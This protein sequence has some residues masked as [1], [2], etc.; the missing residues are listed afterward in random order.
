[1]ITLT[2]IIYEGN[3]EEILR[4]ESWFFKFTNTNITNKCLIINNITSIDSFN[5]KLARLYEEGLI[6]DVVYVKHTAN[7]AIRYFKLDL[8]ENSLGYNYT[9]PYF[10]MLLH[11]KTPYVLN[12]ASDCMNDLLVT[13]D[14]INESINILSTEDKLTSTMV[15][16]IKNNHI[17]ENYKT[18]GQHEEIE[19]FGILNTP[20][21][22][23]PMF[24]VRANFTDQFFLANV[25]KL[26]QID[27]LISQNHTNK[28]YNGPSYGGNSFEKRIVDHH[29]LNNQY[30]G[31]YTGNDYYIHDKKYY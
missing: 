21:I 5:N 8:D 16:W 18:V 2:T 31:V 15:S 19:T 28:I 20:Q 4:S 10:V 24:N 1:M 3:F 27:Y 12:I 11:I 6:F 30:N 23:V 17:M 14:Y 22:N 25:K 26:K 7:N 13:N 9:I 29:I